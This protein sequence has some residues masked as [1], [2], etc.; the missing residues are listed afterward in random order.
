MWLFGGVPGAFCDEAHRRDV[1]AFLTPRAQKH[2][3]A[4]HALDDA[5]EGARTCELTL[6]RNRAAIAK[7]LARF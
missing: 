4:P 3:G 7:F 5:L 6:A 2:A 1:A